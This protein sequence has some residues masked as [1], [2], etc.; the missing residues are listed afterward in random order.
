[1]SL[2]DQ[3][4]ADLKEAMKSKDTQ[5]LTLIRGIM[6]AFKDAE[7]RKREDLT[8][9]AAQKHGVTRPVPKGQSDADKAAYEADLASYSK[10]LDAAT[11]A[12]KV[13]E[14][15]VLDET[16]MLSSI[17]KL[18]KMRQDS[19]AD[20]QK[21]G[22][23]DIVQAEEKELGQLQAYLPQQLSREE[24]E[25]EARAII[26]QVGAAG[27]R[28]MGKV[29]GPLSGKLKGRADGKL[30]SEVVKTLLGSG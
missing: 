19:I 28:D 9:Q 15:A 21:A 23:S 8:K 27:P 13:D 11:A 1:M 16:E 17:Q 25:A 2:K 29:M 26:D 12:E 24:I 5:R 18:I 22:R 3:L 7:I 20:G 14:N 10:A 4:N 6:A 30:I